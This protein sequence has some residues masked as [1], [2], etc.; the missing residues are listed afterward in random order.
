MPTPYQTTCREC[1]APRDPHAHT[2][3]CTRPSTRPPRHAS[4]ARL[5]RAIRTSIPG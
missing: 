1:G 2:A 5:I 4:T 3:R